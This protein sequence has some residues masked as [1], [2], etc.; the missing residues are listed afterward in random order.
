LEVIELSIKNSIILAQRAPQ[1]FNRERNSY[2]DLR[3]AIPIVNDGFLRGMTASLEDSTA[4]IIQAAL[5][6]PRLINFSVVFVLNNDSVISAFR[7]TLARLLAQ[8]E[9][10]QIPRN[11]LSIIEGDI[12]DFDRHHCAVIVNAADMEMRRN[13]EIFDRMRVPPAMSRQI[14]DEAV[15]YVARFNTRLREF[16]NSR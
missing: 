4:R 12:L 1:E 16:L 15:D 8:S 3:I 7:T 14:S 13:H 6:A 9:Y 2:N 10:R 11:A 5:D